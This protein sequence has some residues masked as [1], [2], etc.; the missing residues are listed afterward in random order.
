MYAIGR[1][2]RDAMESA[3]RS[4]VFDSLQNIP[5]GRYIPMSLG[6]LMRPRQEIDVDEIIDHVEDLLG[7]EE[8]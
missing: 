6:E 7:S 2:R 1:C 5:Q 3:W 8:S 4:L